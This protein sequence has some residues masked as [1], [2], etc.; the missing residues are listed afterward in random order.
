V[1]TKEERIDFYNL[2]KLI[3]PKYDPLN[4]KH[5]KRLNHLVTMH[6]GDKSKEIIDG[7][8]SSDQWEKLGFQ[9]KDPRTD[10]RGSGYAGLDIFIR[11]LEA[12][13]EPSQA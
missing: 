12:N 8:Y 4:P 2:K 11:Y 9:G 13:E 7:G 6:F 3:E 5:V 1:L 10:F